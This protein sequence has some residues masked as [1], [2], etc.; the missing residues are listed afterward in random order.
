MFTT[1]RVLKA[2]VIYM[3]I[4]VRTL[5]MTTWQFDESAWKEEGSYNTDGEELLMCTHCKFGG[6]ITGMH[7]SLG[8]ERLIKMP[9]VTVH[10]G[11]ELYWARPAQDTI[12]QEKWLI[13][14]LFIG[15][16]TNACRGL[17][18]GLATYDYF[19]D[20]LVKERLEIKRGPG[21]PRGPWRGSR[22]SWAKRGMIY[23]LYNSIH[24]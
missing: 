5:I 23:F 18:R 8:P 15:T 7:G 16:T 3:L 2:R 20:L 22:G 11:R 9:N 13:H 6:Q 1:L 21:T 24:K 19:R 4:K 14:G 17:T 12:L 10:H